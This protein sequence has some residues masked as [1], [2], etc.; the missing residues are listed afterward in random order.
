[1]SQTKPLPPL[2]LYQD[3]PSPN[4]FQTASPAG[5]PPCRDYDVPPP[6]RPEPPLITFVIDA[7]GLDVEAGDDEIDK[8]WERRSW[9]MRHWKDI[10]VAYRTVIVMA[11]LL[12]LWCVCW[13][14]LR[15]LLRTYRSSHVRPGL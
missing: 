5:P 9:C 1:M 11:V 8:P 2:P 6:Y 10:Q 14:G 4:H 7:D 12:G 15:F 3:L 13:S